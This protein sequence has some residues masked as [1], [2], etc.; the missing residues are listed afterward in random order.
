MFKQVFL[1]QVSAVSFLKTLGYLYEV[2]E[3]Q[4]KST[5]AKKVALR[6]AKEDVHKICIEV[7]KTSDNADRKPTLV[8][9]FNTKN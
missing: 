5:S 4:E 9:Q 2:F 1:E 3:I 7:L 6:D 8:S